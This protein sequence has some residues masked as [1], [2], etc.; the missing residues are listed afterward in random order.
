M[1]VTSRFVIGVDPGTTTGVV[2]WDRTTNS[3]VEETYG[4][5]EFTLEFISE[6]PRNILFNGEEH[7]ILIAER[8]D[9]SADTLRKS[10]EGIDDAIKVLGM[11]WAFSLLLRMEFHRIGRSNSKNFVSD[12]ALKKR[13]L[14]L[15]SRHTRDALR[16]AV[17]WLAENDQDFAKWWAHGSR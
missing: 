9:L 4:D 16:V 15:N 10:R 2:V 11:C 3:V 14:W 17:T 5:P 7:P 6:L 1:T 13:G 8:F 12:E